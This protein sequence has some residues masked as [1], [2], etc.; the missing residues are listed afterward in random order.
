[1]SKMKIV[2]G[3]VWLLVTD[4][5]KEIHRS[6]C[7][8]LYALHQ[9]GSESLIE[10]DEQLNRALEN[11]VDIGIDVGDLNNEEDAMEVV[12]VQLKFYHN[13]AMHEVVFSA[14]SKEFWINVN[15]YD[16]NYSEEYNLISVFVS[17][18]TS[19]TSIYSIKIKQDGK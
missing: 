17:G 7:F 2:E 6:E 5:A 9:D 18:D 12:D 3:F 15:G 16:I 19:F 4:K 11:G 14:Y 1:M 13:K 8:E 10:S